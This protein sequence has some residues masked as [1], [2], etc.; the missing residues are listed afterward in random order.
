MG[1]LGRTRSKIAAL[2]REYVPRGGGF[3]EASCGDGGLLA[4]LSD[5][6]EVRGT[7][8][9]AYTLADPALAPA[10]VTGVDLRRKLPVEPDSCDCVVLSETLQNIPDHGAVLGNL[11]EAL[12]PGGRFILTTPNMQS[13]NSR[14]HFLFTGFFKIKWPFI[15]FD[16][17]LDK[18]FSFH[19]HPAHLPVLLYYANAHGLVPVRFDG[20]KIK[21]KSLAL[22]ALLAW[23]IIPLTW[24]AARKEKNLRNSGASGLVHKGLTSW[25]SLCA[26]RLAIVF[27][28]RQGI[29]VGQKTTELADWAEN[30]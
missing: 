8:H 14:L 7:N 22:Y 9:S 2:V 16:V 11:A 10:V 20:V 23:L 25:K 26:D 5:E 19:N 24:F 13:I 4:F 27:E 1:T 28:K 29:G 30:A 15:G 17:P 6:Y 18:S 3:L 21:A 12:K